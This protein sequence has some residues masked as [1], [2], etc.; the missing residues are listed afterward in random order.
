[1][2][3]LAQVLVDH[4][5]GSTL[6]GPAQMPQHPTTACR[7]LVQLLDGDLT[8]RP[9]LLLPLVRATDSPV[10]DLRRLHSLVLDGPDDVGIVGRDHLHG[11]PRG[12][13]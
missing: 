10:H 12:Q 9:D 2:R 8:I 11:N 3:D 1:M 5:L 7:E 4:H 6:D 13:W